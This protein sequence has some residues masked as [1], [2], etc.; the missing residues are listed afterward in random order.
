MLVKPALN[1]EDAGIYNS[2]FD[3]RKKHPSPA[4]RSRISQSTTLNQATTVNKTELHEEGLLYK[5]H[6]WGGRVFAQKFESVG[7]FY[8]M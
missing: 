8:K 7:V 6:F 3:S 2:D 5:T 1:L 4:A